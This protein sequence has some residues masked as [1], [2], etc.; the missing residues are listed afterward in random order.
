MA[1]LLRKAQWAKNYIA[2]IKPPAAKRGLKL[3]IGKV[4]W[5]LRS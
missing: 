4:K 1:G 3:A 5:K 2:K